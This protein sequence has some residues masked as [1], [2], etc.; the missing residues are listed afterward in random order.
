MIETGRI[1]LICDHHLYLFSRILHVATRGPVRF[2][3]EE[4]GRAAL[5]GDPLD[6]WEYCSLVKNTLPL[7]DDPAGALS[8]GGLIHEEAHI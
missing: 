2:P 5:C 3:P 7:V 4:R 1:S 8:R 6:G